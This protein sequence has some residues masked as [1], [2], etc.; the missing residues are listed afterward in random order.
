MTRGAVP[1]EPL[2]GAGW[3]ITPTDTL[4]YQV[5]TRLGGDTRAVSLRVM[6]VEAGLCIRTLSHRLAALARGGWLE[7]EHPPLDGSTPKR[8]RVL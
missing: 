8:Y 7:V 1:L 5:I 3:G 4:L 2:P 6:S